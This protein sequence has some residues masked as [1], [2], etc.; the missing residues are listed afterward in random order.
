MK[1]F[2]QAWALLKDWKEVA[3]RIEGGRKH[4]QKPPSAGDTLFP[5]ITQDWQ[6]SALSMLLGMVQPDAVT[7]TYRGK[8]GSKEFP[9]QEHHLLQPFEEGEY[10]EM[11]HEDYYRQAAGM[12]I[13]HPMHKNL[14]LWL[15][16]SPEEDSMHGLWE[17]PGGKVERHHRN[18]QHTAE[19][20]VME[21][22]GLPVSNVESIGQHTDHDMQKVYHGFTGDAEH[23]QVTL[24]RNPETGVQEHD[25]YVWA[26][27]ENMFD[28]YEGNVSHHAQH[29]LNQPSE[30]EQE[31][32]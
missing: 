1:P 17:L 25:D 9:P 16:R 30:P 21:E 14:L 6:P 28:R 5:G 7:P 4:L 18:P 8:K 2:D 19:E 12:A 26:S 24:P 11:N 31:G 32:F 27:P 15:R 3:D 13:R 10:S 22:C 20:E 29:L 23:G